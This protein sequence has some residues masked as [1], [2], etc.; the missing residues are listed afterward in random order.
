VTQLQVTPPPAVGRLVRVGRRGVWR[1]VD[2]FTEI[3]SG[4]FLLK[5]GFKFG[6]PNGGTMIFVRAPWVSALLFAFALLLHSGSYAAWTWRFWEWPLQ[7]N[8]TKLKEEIA[9]NVPWLGAIFAGVYVALYARFSAQFNYLAGVY[10]QIMQTAA[11]TPSSR[12]SRELLYIWWAGFIEDSLDLHLATKRT[13]SVVVWFML[14]KPPVYEEFVNYTVDGKTRVKEL[15]TALRCAI[16]DE[17]LETMKANKGL[18]EGGPPTPD[19]IRIFSAYHEAGHAVAAVLRAGGVRRVVLRDPI[20]EG[21]VDTGR[22]RMRRTRHTSA[23]RDQ[24]FVAFAGPYAE[25]RIRKER[26]EADDMDLWDWLDCDADDHAIGDDPSD[27]YVLMGYRDAAAD[28][29]AWVREIEPHWS[30][31]DAVAAIALAN[32]PVNTTVIRRCLDAKAGPPRCIT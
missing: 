31:I 6:Q 22:R 29:E 11:S 4:E 19:L 30:A 27:D 23:R 1:P 17:N 28:L 14:E 24:P 18:M 16:G 2:K 26:E 7:I 25:W 9:G 8:T 32:D 20:N 21:L 3:V 5:L 13:F 12:K 15:I 10:N